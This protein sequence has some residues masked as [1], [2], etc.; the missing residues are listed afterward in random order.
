MPRGIA[1]EAA[2]PRHQ[3]ENGD[4]ES[5][6]GENGRRT[7]ARGFSDGAMPSE[8]FQFLISNAHGL[9]SAV[10]S[11]DRAARQNGGEQLT[12]LRLTTCEYALIGNTC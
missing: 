9:T 10:L 7:G 8:R 12:P 2:E 4:A 1:S 11:C 3:D 5:A 6:V